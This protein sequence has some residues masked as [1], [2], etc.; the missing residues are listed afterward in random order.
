MAWF[1]FLTGFIVA[2]SS[3]VVTHSPNGGSLLGVLV[4]LWGA[5]LLIR[6]EVQDV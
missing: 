5:W 4:A 6:R 3:G 1:L 2:V